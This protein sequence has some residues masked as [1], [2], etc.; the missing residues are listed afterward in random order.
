MGL[1][2]VANYDMCVG[3][4]EICSKCWEEKKQDEFIPRYPLQINGHQETVPNTF[5]R[6]V[7][8]HVG[9]IRSFVRQNF[10]CRDWDA[11]TH[12]MLKHPH[13][14][15]HQM[16]NATKG[17]DVKIAKIV[18]W[19][20]SLNFGVIPVLGG[21]QLGKTMT[22]LWLAEIMHDIKPN[23]PIC[24]F[25]KDKSLKH[26]DWMIL[27]DD[28]KEVPI[29]AMLIID[30]GGLRAF[31]GDHMKTQ[32]KWLVKLCAIVGHK[33]LIILIATQSLNILGL[34]PIRLLTALITKPISDVAR[35]F[36]ERGV[37]EQLSHQI[38]LDVTETTIWNPRPPDKFIISF[39]QPMPRF[40]G[41]EEFRT[42]FADYDITQEENLFK[43]SELKKK[44]VKIV[45]CNDCGARWP[46]RSVG[47]PNRCPRCGKK[48]NISLATH[49]EDKSISIYERAGAEIPQMEAK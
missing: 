34:S 8:S 37:I 18:S 28:L 40:I 48:G 47:L 3:C 9:A 49:T 46:S 44:E 4:N 19:L 31:A 41:L 21:Q 24:Y 42:A 15:Y 5:F 23:K 1:L 27:A 43:V 38:P 2:G 20:W 10:H 26:P 35:A 11:Q 16:D 17:N 22:M 13:V 39:W 32:Q 7:Y 14:A 45:L 6:W 30:E 33:R 29:G 12:W 36:G 25:T